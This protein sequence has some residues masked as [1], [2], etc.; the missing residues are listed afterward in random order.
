MLPWMSDSGDSRTSKSELHY[1]VDDTWHASIDER[2]GYRAACGARVL[3]LWGAYDEALANRPR[4]AECE[5]HA[6]EHDTP[7]DAPD[8]PA[9]PV[10]AMAAGFGPHITWIWLSDVDR[11]DAHWVYTGLERTSDG[12][13]LA[14]CGAHCTIAPDAHTAGLSRCPQCTGSATVLVHPS[15]HRL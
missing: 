9:H 13:Y 2:C 8:P 10:T 4:C 7:Q 6:R 12:R 5:A 14:E 15:S 1:V 3:P 11:Q